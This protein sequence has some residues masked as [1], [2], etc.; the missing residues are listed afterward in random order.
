MQTNQ[1]I[2][3]RFLTI[4]LITS[5]VCGVITY[6]FFDLK[7]LINFEIA[8][9][10]SMVVVAATFLA[11]TKKVKN[12]NSDY[13]INEDED[14]ELDK[15]DDKHELFKKIKESTQQKTFNPKRVVLGS[16]LFFSIYR[17]LAYLFLIVAIVALIKRGYFEVI[18][19]LAGTTMF[20]LST[21]IFY[22]L[23]KK[24]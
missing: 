7:T 10:L 11:Y 19:F 4:I 24:E 22:A 18:S 15:I 2:V 8:Y 23:E 20:I 6:L 16:K 9:F 5:T 13:A 3:T 12:E 1:K 14:D 17:I 21:I